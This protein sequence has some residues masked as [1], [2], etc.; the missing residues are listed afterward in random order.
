MFEGDFSSLS[1]GDF[2]SDLNK[3]L[4]IGRSLANPNNIIH[5]GTLN[6]L[7]VPI[8]S[9]SLTSQSWLE[10]NGTTENKWFGES[11]ALG[12][13]DGDEFNDLIIG[14]PGPV[15]SPGSSGE[16]GYTHVIFGQPPLPR[17][18]ESPQTRVQPSIVRRGNR[19]SMYFEIENPNVIWL[20][21]WLGASLFKHGSS[22]NPVR[23]HTQE[24][25]IYWSQQSLAFT[26]LCLVC[27]Q[28]TLLDKDRCGHV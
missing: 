26:M 16:P 4:I 22:I 14:V 19:I 20:D 10:I 5:A 6:I 1:V 7:N 2:D 28:V 11:I 13:I 18:I 9:G 12:D 3:D 8:Q 25:L 23:I 17:I 24:I 15:T 21:A 27:I